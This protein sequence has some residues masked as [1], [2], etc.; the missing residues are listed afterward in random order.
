[1]LQS[2]KLT[3]TMCAVSF[4]PEE[5]LIRRS[6]KQYFGTEK[7]LARISGDTLV[8][9][10]SVAKEFGIKIEHQRSEEHTLEK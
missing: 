10:E 1:M 2:K 7:A 5:I 3:K 9:N 6:G 8:I 4:G